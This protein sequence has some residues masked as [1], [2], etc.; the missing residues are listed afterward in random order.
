MAPVGRTAGRSLRPKPS[1]CRVKMGPTSPPATA[2]LSF[3]SSPS[4]AASMR[5]LNFCVG[6]AS[7][8]PADRPFAAS[9]TPRRPRRPLGAEPPEKIRSA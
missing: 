8:P 3:R 1:A 7:G 6:M 9:P 2:P 4:K 5:L